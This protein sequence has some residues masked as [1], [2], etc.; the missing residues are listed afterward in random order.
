MHRLSS[1]CV[2]Q[3]E[4]HN[5]WHDQQASRRGLFTH[6][7]ASTSEPEVVSISSNVAVGG[8]QEDTAGQASFSPPSFDLSG[9]TALVVGG[10]RGLGFA[11]A[12]AL[13][14]AGAHVLVAARTASDVERASDEISEHYGSAEPVFL[15][16]TDTENFAQMLASMP[17]LD[18]LVNSA[19][20]NRPG[21]FLDV[22]P[23]DYDAVMAV[24]VRSAFFV[25]QA[26]AAKMVSA[27]RGGSIINM[28]SQMGHVGAANRSVYCASKWAME[29]MTKA[30]AIELAPHGIRINTV[31]PT[32]IETPMTTPFLAD[33]GF[34]NEVLSKI[35]LGRIGQ[36]QDVGGAVV[37]LASTSSAL[38]TGSAILLDGG[39]TA[40]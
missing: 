36:P 6:L 16:V 12:A 20:T 2:S 10:S 4:A 17:S 5:T 18:I 30:M 24:N 28:S 19:G 39:W 38:M 11:S 29:G 21:P 27:R 33:P 35:K 7:R 26:V 34:R 25:T 22:S 14:A 23:G 1:A 37:F 31:A 40:E 15:D 13:A 3:C 8:Q 32:F 9:K